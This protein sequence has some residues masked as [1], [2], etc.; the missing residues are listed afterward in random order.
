MPRFQILPAET[1][2]YDLFE[3]H[4]QILQRAARQLREL[5]EDFNDIDGKFAQITET[6][7]QG[8]FV[9]HEVIDLARRSFL[10]PFDTEDVTAIA[11]RID[12]G[13]D[14]IQEA[15][16]TM[17][18]WKVV[19][20]RPEAAVLC[21]IIEK[22]A[23]EIAAAVPNLRD[24]R[25]FDQV[26]AHI[27]EVN[28]LENEADR[29]A[30]GALSAVLAQHDDVYDLLRWKEIYDQLEAVTDRLEDV[31]DVLEGITVKHG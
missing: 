15:A 4:A 26:R 6:E 20:P 8:D 24:K 17:I 30:R 28:R 7:H 31:A 5:V 2:F 14:G 12:D 10:A 27:V 21:R 11:G 23:D 9:T 22:G 13:I 3:Q 16:D 1:R 18:L 25:R 19:Q 29:I